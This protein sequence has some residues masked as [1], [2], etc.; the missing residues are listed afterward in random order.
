M[1][2]FTEEDG[3]ERMISKT[4]I[5]MHNLLLGSNLGKII[6]KNDASR[7]HNYCCRPLIRN[8]TS[9]TCRKKKRCPITNA[10]DIKT[11]SGI[12]DALEYKN[13]DRINRGN[14]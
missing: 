10:L 8:H 4:R 14:L 6:D 9:F 12:E 3:L 11:N 1:K 2:I 5:I 7:P 13:R